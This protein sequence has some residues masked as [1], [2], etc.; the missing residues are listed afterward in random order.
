M[1]VHPTV[2]GIG[3]GNKKTPRRSNNIIKIELLLLLLVVLCTIV[4]CVACEIVVR[5]FKHVRT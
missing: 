2:R 1:A 3:V 4:Y 5:S